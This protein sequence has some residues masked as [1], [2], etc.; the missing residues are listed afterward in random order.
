M[1]RFYQMI[2]ARSPNPSSC[3][4]EPSIS[5]SCWRRSRRA[6]RCLKQ[7]RR[8]PPASLVHRS[9]PPSDLW[10]ESAQASLN[11]SAFLPLK[12]KVKKRKRPAKKEKPLKD[13][14]GN[15]IGSPHFSD[16]PS[17][18]GEVKVCV[19]PPSAAA[20]AHLQQRKS[21]T[22]VCWAGWWKREVPHEE[23]T[24]EGQQREQGETGN[25]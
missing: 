2:R 14:Q 3:R 13:E 12:T 11:H 9:F 25:S 5:S 7:E 18:E 16:N 1:C 15:D 21:L 8:Y 6:A 4:P 22:V 20:S 23:E 24:K 17:E 19:K 10:P